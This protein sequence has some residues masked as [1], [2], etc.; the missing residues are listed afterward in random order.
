MRRNRASLVLIEQVIML[1]VFALASA[2][3]I[4]AFAWADTESAAAAER[5]KALL[6]AQNAAQII[7]NSGDIAAAELLG[8][9][10]EGERWII[11][12]DEEWQ[13][14]EGG[15]VY[16]LTAEPKEDG[17]RYMSAA[18]VEVYKGAE[19]LLSVDAAWQEVAKDEG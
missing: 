10:A 9:C 2:L 6:M 16:T 5:D 12:Y 18:R 1:L 7:K 19:L 11:Y 3:C 8:G 17:L 13:S 15:G 14:V 4:K